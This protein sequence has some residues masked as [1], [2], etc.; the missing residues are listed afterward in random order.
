MSSDPMFSPAEE[1]IARQFPGAFTPTSQQSEAL[2]GD[3][4][5][6]YKGETIRWKGLFHVLD[7]QEHHCQ[8]M[9]YAPAKAHEVLLATLH[10][11][12]VGDVRDPARIAAPMY[13]GSPA[14]FSQNHLRWQ[15]ACH[16]VEA[17]Y[18]YLAEYLPPEVQRHHE[19]ID[20]RSVLAR[21]SLVTTDDP[22]EL[23][24]LARHRAKTPAE[25]RR[26]HHARA[27]LVFAQFCFEARRNHYA[28]ETLGQESRA[29]DTFVSRNLFEDPEGEDVNV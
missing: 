26:R 5:A 6:L 9:G 11:Y 4:H 1:R 20:L 29:L 16:D 27:K 8:R 13:R 10:D 18:T 19:R 25:Q 15:Q 3:E 21:P 23:I 14:E 7:H 22:I 17:T 28:P 12:F 2:L 24:R